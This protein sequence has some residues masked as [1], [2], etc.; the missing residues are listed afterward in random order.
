V[1]EFKT[2]VGH[3]MMNLVKNFS[4]P[5][6]HSPLLLMNT[7]AQY[8]TYYGAHNMEKTMP[9]PGIPELLESLK[10]RGIQL[11]VYSNKADEFS[12]VIVEHYFPGTFEL[13]RG[14]VEGVP[15]KPDPTLTLAAM[16]ELGVEPEEC[17]F[18]GDSGVDI[19]TGKNSGAVPVGETW[20][21]RKKEELLDCGARYIINKP[22]EL[23]SVIENL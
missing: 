5:E 10:N 13:I 15:V 9:Y 21:Y 2:M 14:K 4:P 3:G 17:I 18:I 7:L 20:G 23:F 22:E 19:L 11:A 8:M 12:C 6:F 1:E 16:K